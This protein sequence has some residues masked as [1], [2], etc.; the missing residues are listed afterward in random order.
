MPRSG[1]T[2]VEQILAS[3]TSVEGAG[4]LSSLIAVI[5]ELR[6]KHS[7]DANVGTSDLLDKEDLG[8]VGQQYLERCLPHRKLMRP[9]FTDKMPTNFRHLGAIHTILPN[10]KIIDVRRHPLACCFSNFK[11]IFPSDMGPSY[12]LADM[13]CYYRDYVEL[14][15]HFDRV[16]PGRVHRVIY[17][18]MIADPEGEIRRLLDYCGLQ[19]EDQCLRFYENDRGVRTISSEQVRRPVY[20]D[21]LEQWRHFEPWLDP[22][23]VA[24]GPV[25]TAYPA[26]PEEF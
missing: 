14:M 15:A 2:L 22:L 24:L 4:E 1:S 18:D 25:L 8:S 16:L 6:A 5:R 9:F 23:K 3:H 7:G 26:V 20:R 13:G 17:E 12:D 19:F 10:A 11:Q 21:S